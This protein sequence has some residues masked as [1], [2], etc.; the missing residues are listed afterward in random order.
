MNVIFLLQSVKTMEFVRIISEGLI[1]NVWRVLLVNFVNYP[2][3][4]SLRHKMV[5]AKARVILVC[6]LV[7]LLD[8]LWCCF[9][10]RVLVII[11]GIAKSGLTL[12]SILF[13]LIH[14]VF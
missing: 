1:V 3:P 6:L 14:G 8:V 2:N 10:L 9:S 12:V 13:S 11:G 4:P 5:E 7:F